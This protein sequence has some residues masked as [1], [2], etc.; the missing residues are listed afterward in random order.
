[1]RAQAK[2]L[3]ELIFNSISHQTNSSM[4]MLSIINTVFLPLTFLAG[5]FGTN[6]ESVTAYKWPQGFWWFWG[7]CAIVTGAF[8]V[9]L[10]CW[11]MFR[12]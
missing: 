11:G 2:E 8:M 10:R 3:I 6:F 4:A 7:L 9:L 5:V 1:M 12:R